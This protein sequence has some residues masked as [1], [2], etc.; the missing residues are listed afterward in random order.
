M[1][2]AIKAGRRRSADEI[3]SILDELDTS[4]ASVA[5]FAKS[6][7]LA[8]ST[9]HSWRRSYDRQC[10]VKK[11]NAGRFVPVELAE[12]DVAEQDAIEIVLAGGYCVRVRPGFCPQTLVA[13]I[14][15]LS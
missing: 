15:A 10:S 12:P 6:R 5:S 3:L 4:G 11:A 7:G 1:S 2:A 14:D 9:V 8:L 13:V